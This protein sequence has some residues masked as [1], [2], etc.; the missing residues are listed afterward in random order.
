MFFVVKDVQS[1]NQ[2]HGV[3][4]SRQNDASTHKK[5]VGVLHRVQHISACWKKFSVES[6][7]N[8]R[9]MMPFLSNFQ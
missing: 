6:L 4:F 3:S 8:E 7:K 5:N 9:L 1:Q 2:V